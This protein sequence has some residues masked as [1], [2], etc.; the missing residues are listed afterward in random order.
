MPSYIRPLREGRFAL[1]ALMQSALPL[2]NNAVAS[3]AGSSFRVGGIRS[4][5]S[6]HQLDHT[7]HRTAGYLNLLMPPT[8][9]AVFVEAWACENLCSGSSWKSLS[10]LSITSA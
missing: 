10:L 1:R 5:L 8:L 6:R 2:L 7:S 4:D 3:Q 9:L